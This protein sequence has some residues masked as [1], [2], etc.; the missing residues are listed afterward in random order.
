M[1]AFVAI[2]SVRS[3]HPYILDVNRAPH[4]QLNGCFVICN[5][6]DWIDG[7]SFHLGFI[8]QSSFLDTYVQIWR[9]RGPQRRTPGLSPHSWRL[10][11][12]HPMLAV[13]AANRI[14]RTVCGSG[15]DTA[16]FVVEHADMALIVGNLFCILV[17]ATSRSVPHVAWENKHAHLWKCRCSRV[18]SSAKKPIPVSSSVKLGFCDKQNCVDNKTCRYMVAPSYR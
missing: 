13:Q 3:L 2:V 16:R 17:K 6:E 11:D 5:M 14:T 18:R 15:I 8:S 7:V 10:S 12:P 4:H 9:G 1:C